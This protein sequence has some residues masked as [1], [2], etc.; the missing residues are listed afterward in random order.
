VDDRWAANVEELR[1]GAV[2]QGVEWLHGA[3][4]EM[5]KDEIRALAAAGGVQGR[6]GKNWCPLAALRHGLEKVLVPAR[7]VGCVESGF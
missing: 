4:S 6:S 1:E 7:E 3:L 2:S 5:S